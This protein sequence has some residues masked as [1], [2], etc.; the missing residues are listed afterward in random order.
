MTTLHILCNPEGPVHYNR[1]IDAFSIACW[2]FIKYMSSY[3]WNCILYGPAGSEVQC[4]FVQCLDDI[5]DNHDNNVA[6]YNLRAGIEIN[7]RKKAGDIIVCFYGHE[8]RGAAEANQDLKAVEP[9]I[10]YTHEAVF[11]PHRIFVSY[12]HMHIYYGKNNMSLSPSWYDDVIYNPITKDEFE[13]C[14]Q[15]DD[16]YLVFG[17]V[18]KL[19]GIDLAIQ[20]TEYMGKKLVIAG[21]GSLEYMGYDKVPKHVE[22]I[23]T[24]D[25]EQRKQIMSKAKAILGL[26]YYVEP[27]GNMIAEA[28]MSG[29]PAIT[30]DWGAFVETVNPKVGF[31]CRDFRDVVNAMENIDSI[32][33]IDC[34]NHA[35]ENFEDEIIHPQFNNYF[36]KIVDNNFYRT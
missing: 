8:N 10:G 9:S 22:M 25:I 3:G 14:D 30:T 13:F 34:R 16:Y 32:K 15:K 24:C 1:R 4:E 36:K 29:T 33:H 17:R 27:F 2:K 19:K 28:F 7:K 35:L 5:S 23:G 21:H 20:A 11:A 12:A 26:T 18:T 6:S 31:R